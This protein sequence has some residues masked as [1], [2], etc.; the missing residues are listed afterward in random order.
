M[1]IRIGINGFGRIGRQV[2]KTIKAYHPDAVDIVAF[3]DLGDLATMA[4]LFKYDSTH[5]VYEGSVE[6]SNSNLV[7]D[8]D[9]IKALSVRNPEELPWGDL[10]VD[11]VVESTG[12]F[13]DH[14]GA[15]KH[16]TAGCK[17]SYY[18]CSR[19]RTRHHACLRCE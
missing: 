10:G 19:Q 5:G 4:H 1:A 9:E 8:G 3:N 18:L 15:S 2:V 16:I 17:E 6:V 13:R 14:A 7:V 12:I 11:I